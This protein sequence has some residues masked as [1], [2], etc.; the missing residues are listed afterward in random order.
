[1][2]L[3]VPAR[4][5][6]PPKSGLSRAPSGGGLSVHGMWMPGASG[7]HLT[8]RLRLTGPR[9][10]LRGSNLLSE[11]EGPESIAEGLFVVD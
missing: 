9:R 10:S 7:Q 6:R 3:V 8:L 5:A 4:T 11:T 2:K 1:M